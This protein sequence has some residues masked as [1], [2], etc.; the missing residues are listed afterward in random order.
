MLDANQ[1]PLQVQTIYK[2]SNETT[3]KLLTEFE[4]RM[5]EKET[6]MVR[7]IEKYEL[8]NSALMTKIAEL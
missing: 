3:E 1:A 5:K 2:Q 6:Q 4:K 8:K 7:E